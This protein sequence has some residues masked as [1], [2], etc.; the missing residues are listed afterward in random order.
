MPAASQP[1]Q[2]IRA[3]NPPL[4]GGQGG[5]ARSVEAAGSGAGPASPDL[6]PLVPQLGAGT[7]ALPKCLRCLGR[8]KPQATPLPTSPRPSGLGE[9][10]VSM[11]GGDAGGG[12]LRCVVVPRAGLDI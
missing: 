1:V 10:A 12:S 3:V 6:P 2:A 5:G 8:R 4:A 7:L 9:G 11:R